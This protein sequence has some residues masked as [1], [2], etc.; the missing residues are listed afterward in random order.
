MFGFLFG[1][2]ECVWG[3]T[4]ART[5]GNG[6]HGIFVWWGGE[7]NNW[8]RI[9]T[10]SHGLFVWVGGVKIFK[11]W[12]G[13]WFMVKKKDNN[14]GKWV[15]GVFVIIG[16]IVIFNFLISDSND[17]E[18]Y[19]ESKGYEILEEGTYKIGEESRAYVDMKSFGNRRDQAMAGLISLER[20]Y[21]NVDGY[22]V[23]IIEER[24]ECL[25]IIPAVIIKPNFDS[26]TSTM[27]EEKIKET[28]DYRFWKGVAKL[29][30]E[31][32]L[33]G[34]EF[35]ILLASDYERL[36]ETGLDTYH[37]LSI[38]YFDIDDRSHCE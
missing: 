1:F 8:S 23:K 16:V 38:L 30:Y 18:S 32:S 33:R 34:E 29:E 19:L 15:I 12:V 13:G 22:A 7:G 37:L 35:D 25:Y 3:I 17:K 9:G 21:P 20:S 31:K 6:G 11:D 24:A 26:L 10:D 4:R 27:D 5:E 2:W 14:V 28:I 36:L